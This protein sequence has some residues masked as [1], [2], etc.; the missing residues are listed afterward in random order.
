MRDV[1]SLIINLVRKGVDSHMRGL[2]VKGARKGLA[3]SAAIPFYVAYC[4]CSGYDHC[5]STRLAA[6]YSKAKLPRAA[7]GSCRQ[8]INRNIRGEISSIKESPGHR[9]VA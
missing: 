7:A 4:S 2:Y 3:R 1:V 6:P 9:L 8:S 5:F